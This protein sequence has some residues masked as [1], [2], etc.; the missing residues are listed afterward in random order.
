MNLFS[1]P[2]LGAAGLLTAPTLWSALVGDLRFD[3]GLSRYLIAVALCWAGLTVVAMLV[4]PPT[5]RV[6]VREQ[7]VSD[8]LGGKP[9]SVS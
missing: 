3:V 4:G 5:Q 2:V 9:P 8:A 1:L 7:E 6:G